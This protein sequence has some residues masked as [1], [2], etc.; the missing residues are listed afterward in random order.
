MPAA[1][2]RGEACAGDAEEDAD[3]DVGGGGRGGG[4]GRAGSESSSGSSESSSEGEESSDEEGEGAG[5]TER[6]RRGRRR[7]QQQRARGREQ[8]QRNA[9]PPLPREPRPSRSYFH[10]RED[11]DDNEHADP[12]GCRRFSGNG[13]K[14]EATIKAAGFVGAESE[15]V[16][17]G[18]DGGRF[19][20]FDARTTLLRARVRTAS[21]T[22][23]AFRESP[24]APLHLATVGIDDSVKLLAPVGERRR[25]TRREG[26]GGGGERS[27]GGESSESSDSGSSSESSGSSSSSSSSDGGEQS[28]DSGSSEEEAEEEEEGEQQGGGG[29]GGGGAAGATARTS[30]LAHGGQAR[31]SAW[32]VAQGLPPQAFEGSD[33]GLMMRLGELG[34]APPRGLFLQLAREWEERQAAGQEAGEREGEG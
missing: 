18:G 15:L 25:R 1:I 21:H 12:D 24:S 13:Y 32:L 20:L 3:S 33:V 23:N 14:N 8:R 2:A 28:G 11:A 7:R 4:G 16:A 34:I 30:A 31:R 26:R 5:E 9:P 22:C 29:G 19:F 27:G 10:R 6:D 17:A